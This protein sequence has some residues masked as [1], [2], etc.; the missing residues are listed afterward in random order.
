M[1]VAVA[2]LG[3]MG[4]AIAERLLDAGH[5]VTVHNRTAGKAGELVDRGAREAADRAEVWDRAQVCIT[6]VADSAALEAVAA[7]PDGLIGIDGAR[8]RRSST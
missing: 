2:G 8:G 5:A 1:D 7:G 6:M 4:T 3:R